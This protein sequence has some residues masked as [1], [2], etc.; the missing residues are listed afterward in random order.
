ME[1]QEEHANLTG[2]A[3]KF[4]W[5]FA[6][7]F[8]SYRRKLVPDSMVT[9]FN[10]SDS[11]VWQIHFPWVLELCVMVDREG[12]EETGRTILSWSRVFWFCLS[13][14]ERRISNPIR[15]DLETSLLNASDLLAPIE[16]PVQ[17]EPHCCTWL[18][19]ACAGVWNEWWPRAAQQRNTKSISAY[20][21]EDACGRVFWNTNLFSL[22]SAV[23]E[24][25][26]C[27]YP[28]PLL[29]TLSPSRE[30]LRPSLPH[31]F[32]RPF[33]HMQCFRSGFCCYSHELVSRGKLILHK[34]QK[35][36]HTDV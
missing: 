28:A 24:H 13:A 26:L 9:S 11:F 4:Q 25:A 5:A 23:D 7:M 15:E 27:W 18:L 16:R 12:S 19:V 1:D 33:F 6:I 35:P 29:R 31:Q 30:L 14:H 34:L 2:D 17:L 10:L 36:R 8:S 20:Q 32:L 21:S 22:P 3:F